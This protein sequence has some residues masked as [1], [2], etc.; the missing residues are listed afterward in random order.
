MAMNVKAH[1][2]VTITSACNVTTKGLI[3]LELQIVSQMSLSSANFKENVDKYI[4]SMAYSKI[5][6]LIHV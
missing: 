2:K 4:I 3:P 5:I 6:C 1:R